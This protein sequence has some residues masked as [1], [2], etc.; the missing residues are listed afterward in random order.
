M[1]FIGDNIRKFRTE[2]NLTREDLAKKIKKNGSPIVPRTIL[3]WETGESKPD[4]DSLAQMA[5]IFQKDL[6]LFLPLWHTKKVRL[7]YLVVQAPIVEI[8]RA[9]PA[10]SGHLKELCQPP[11]SIYHQKHHLCA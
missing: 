1:Q 9:K 10:K 5:Q 3:N 2:L 7:G 4:A 11:N 8:Y 6:I